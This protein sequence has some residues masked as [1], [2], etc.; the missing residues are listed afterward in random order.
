V[1][2]QRSISQGMISARPDGRHT[3]Q[4]ELGMR[5][6]GGHHATEHVCRH[7]MYLV[8]ENETPLSRREEF[9]HFLR[10]VRPIV[11]VCD[12]RICG[13]DHP[14]FSRELHVIHNEEDRSPREPKT[15]NH[16]A[17]LFFLIGCEHGNL[18]V[19]YVRPLHELLSPLH[20][21][22]TTSSRLRL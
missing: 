19:C 15:P 6:D 8:Q 7:H 14:A 10:F 22:H 2:L 13:N 17:Y 21:R 16:S 5:F 20:D 12:H 4:A 3:R 18:A 9:H 1:S 11:S